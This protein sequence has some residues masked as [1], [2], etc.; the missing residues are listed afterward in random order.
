MPVTFQDEE[1]GPPKQT[2]EDNEV[3]P[4]KVTF[5]DEDVGPPAKA[6]SDQWN[7]DQID[8]ER[9]ATAAGLPPA[10]DSRSRLLSAIQRTESAGFTTPHFIGNPG[11][12]TGDRGVTRDIEN[13]VTS[14]KKREAAAP[15]EQR[16]AIA[17]ERAYWEEEARQGM[18]AEEWKKQTGEDD[19]LYPYER[20]GEEVPPPEDQAILDKEEQDR[21]ATQLI[22]LQNQSA[23]SDI[24][25]QEEFFRN[26]MVNVSP[27]AVKSALDVVAPGSRLLTGTQLGKGAVE[28]TAEQ[29]SGLT[30][31]KSIAM[32]PVLAAPLVGEAAGI[33]MA[34][35]GLKG[36]WEHFSEAYKKGDQKEI[37]K[38]LAEM[39]GAVTML[40]PFAHGTKGRL[41]PKAEA[42]PPPVPPPPIPT[43]AEVLAPATLEAVKATSGTETAPSAARVEATI[44]PVDIFTR[45]TKAAAEA[46]GKE[47]SAV[48][49]ETETVLRGMQQPEVTPANVPQ[50]PVAGDVTEAGARS[51]PATGT[52]AGAPIPQTAPPTPQ[53][54]APITKEAWQMTQAEYAEKY[55]ADALRMHRLE[56]EIARD[57]GKPVP[58]EVLDE[59][60]KP[61]PPAPEAPPE[62]VI[63]PTTLAEVQKGVEKAIEPQPGT[64]LFYGDVSGKV[65]DVIPKSKFGDY[66][67]AI[68]VTP[69]ESFAKT[70]A[71]G[72]AF[73]S[74]PAG[75]G[76]VHRV[77]IE[78]PKN[79]FS[80]DATPLTE[81]EIKFWNDSGEDMQG[82]ATR[83]DLIDNYGGRSV[84]SADLRDISSAW[85]DFLDKFGYDAVWDGSQLAIRKGSAKIKPTPA[86]PTP[87]A[88]EAKG[89]PVTSGD[90]LAKLTQQEW[91]DQRHVV[92]RLA[93]STSDKGVKAWADNQLKQF[94]RTHEEQ[95][96]L[97][98]PTPSQPAPTPSAKVEGKAPPAE[99]VPP[100]EQPPAPPGPGAMSAGELSPEQAFITSIKN[101]WTDADAAKFGLEPVERGERR[102]W[103][104]IVLPE[105][106]QAILDDPAAADKIIAQVE[107]NPRHQMSDVETAILLQRKADIINEVNRR[108]TM[109]AEARQIG[110]AQGEI[111]SMVRINDLSDELQTIRETAKKAGTPL[112][113]SLAARKM[114]MREDYSLA[115]MLARKGGAVK[116]PLEPEESAQIEKLQKKIEDLEKKLKDKMESEAEGR[117]PSQEQESTDE[118]IKTAEEEKSKGPID[119]KEE[120]KNII[121]RMKKRIEEGDTAEDLYAYVQKLHENLQRQSLDETGK[122]MAREAVVD[123]IHDILTKDLGL[124]LPKEFTGTE[125]AINTSDLI[126]GIGR[127][128]PLTADAAKLAKMDIREQEQKVGK[129]NRYL[130]N[131]A[132]PKT[133]PARK[134]SSAE[135][136]RLEKEGRELARKL[137]IRVTDPATQLANSLSAIKTRLQNEIAEIDLAIAS[138]KP[139]VRGKTG[140]AYD[141]E[142]TELRNQRDI[143][144]AAYDE[145][146]GTPEL[147]DEQKMLRAEKVLDRQIAE[148]Q[149]QLDSGEI[150]PPG[151][152][153]SKVLKS[154]AL[155]AKRAQLTALKSEREYA[156]ELIQPTPEIDAQK[157]AARASML[158]KRIEELQRQID[159]EE[160]FQK[161]KALKPEETAR[162]QERLNQIE[163]LKKER[164]YIR[165][166]IQPSPEIAAKELAAKSKQ[167]DNQIKE[168]QRQLDSG[169]IFPPGKKLSTVE[170]NDFIKAKEDQ[171]AE[172]KK[173]REYARDLLQPGL[174]PNPQLTALRAWRTRTLNR[175]AELKQK[176]AAGDY[177]PKKRTPI[178]PQTPGDIAL[179][180]DLERE[181][182][183]FE[184]DLERDRLAHRSWREQGRD[185]IARWRREFILSS[186][187]SIGKLTS[188][189]I[190]GLTFE[191][192][193]EAVGIGAAKIFPRFYAATELE[194]PTSLAIEAKAKAE[195]FTKLASDFSKTIRGQPTDI[196][197]VYGG[198]QAVPEEMRVWMGQ[199]H[200][201]LKTTLKREAFTRAYAK[202]DQI[203][204]ERGLNPDDPLVEMRIGTQAYKEAMRHLFMEDNV[205]VSAYQRGMSA[206]TSPKA[207]QAKPTLTQV[208]LG[209][210]SKVLLPIVR[211]PTNLVSRSFQAIFGLPVGMTRLTNAYLRDFAARHPI[212]VGE[213]DPKLQ[214]IADAFAKRIEEMPDDQADAISRQLKAG[215]ITGALML[216]AWF[217]PEQFGGYYQPGEKRKSG[218]LKPGRV[219]VPGL[220]FDIPTFLLHRPELEAMQFVATLRKL[221]DSKF[222]KKDQEKMGI[223]E[224]GLAAIVG[225]TDEVPFV[226]EMFDVSKIRNDKMLISEYLKSQAAG[227][228]TPEL[229]KV[230]AQGVEWFNTGDIA[231]RKP[232]G[233]GE[234]LKMGIPGLRQQVP[235]KKTSAQSAA[236][237]VM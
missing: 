198:R 105:A 139:M 121:D 44:S 47:P 167:L 70:F 119:T 188:A 157:V 60:N 158:D 229:L 212:E 45:Q 111:D 2:F 103:R 84:G 81:S 226:K 49:K 178:E 138:K 136:R 115:T 209:T 86:E 234:E 11:E 37:G 156:R 224:A 145:I 13:L 79:V 203:Y 71:E 89:E 52:E 35:E 64:P 76:K 205:L 187:R 25:G 46:V 160:V 220:P 5:R 55:G 61:V 149:R 232:R 144:K 59:L 4:P 181:K 90:E 196:E 73:E 143:K 117:R 51:I 58:P 130:T 129:I 82:V 184:R 179:K 69:D 123:R 104:D 106:Q 72:M 43:V 88:T 18:S 236:Q 15:V 230:I 217:N 172:L 3:G 206:F 201:A 27:L 40:L 94:A 32:L 28:S 150:F 65:T 92:R 100:P 228:L 191:P 168:L 108:K 141:V 175:I 75:S 190:E 107:E 225:L 131:Q 189:A 17:K 222:R 213:K 63:P 9:R 120:Q 96:A 53:T 7:Q 78:Q 57:Q 174:E 177:A 113:Q 26:P 231:S 200:A 16:P 93:E 152:K 56:V 151:K 127:A 148:V 207:G 66:G 170:K 159:A 180:A 23:A 38:G 101:A 1:V 6:K 147:T 215:T 214:Q 97:S 98:K 233:F 30:A 182:L 210:A 197:A 91:Q 62:N 132:A 95:V 146:F 39:G 42:V 24:A 186:L 33:G 54:V 67:S 22:N 85:D 216:Y 48:H 118:A 36:G 164:Q 161:G 237:S 153:P 195:A 112:G 204:R 128:T 208:A 12:P 74:K 109:L 50:V 124:T 183:A 221:A 223:T 116:R 162:N 31:P 137:G 134:P 14:L 155:D 77:E 29:L 235:A 218:E 133:G 8:M 114:L 171:I 80:A 185:M 10:P 219:R 154:D 176:R 20:T 68:Y 21:Q 163:E 122:P 202:L 19:V 83:Q 227:I 165:E 192:I 199:L 34:A 135:A 99:P 169:E 173:Q 41:T 193:K 125:G 166:K 87:S 211:I 142:A 110:D 126:S 194:R 140:V 102:K